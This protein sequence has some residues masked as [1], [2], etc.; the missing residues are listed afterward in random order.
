M[1]EVVMM[2]RPVCQKS[3]KI[4]DFRVNIKI[5]MICVCVLFLFLFLQN[6]IL[7]PQNPVGLTLW[8]C[9]FLYKLYLGHLED[10]RGPQV[11][12]LISHPPCH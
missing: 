11:N 12:S 8:H 4:G 2:I 1:R 9:L 7:I 6:L 5:F 10:Q 3:K